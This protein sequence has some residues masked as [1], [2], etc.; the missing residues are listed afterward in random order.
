[1]PDGDHQ[2]DHQGDLVWF[3]EGRINRKYPFAIG[4]NGEF[5]AQED[6]PLDMQMMDLWIY[7][8]DGSIEA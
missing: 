8:N 3:L 1:M 5:V 6:D 2:G 7:D 4:A